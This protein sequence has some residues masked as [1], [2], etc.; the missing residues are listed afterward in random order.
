MRWG[1]ERPV[2]QP[3]LVRAVLVLEEDFLGKP[4]RSWSSQTRMM[5]PDER[6]YFDERWFG[7][8]RPYDPDMQYCIG[9]RCLADPKDIEG[10]GGPIA[11][12]LAR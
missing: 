12:W 6:A 9:R 2:N 1:I 7:E 3:H 8:V 10:E 11:E 5:T 4:K